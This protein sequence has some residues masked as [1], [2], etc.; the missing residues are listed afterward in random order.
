MLSELRTPTL[1][2]VCV[3]I[4]SHMLFMAG[5]LT[6]QAVPLSVAQEQVDYLSVTNVLGDPIV[7]ITS[8]WA[9]AACVAPVEMARLFF[10]LLRDS[11]NTVDG[12]NSTLEGFERADA[13]GM[14]SPL[15]QA[16][17]RGDAMYSA[18]T[19]S[20]QTANAET[21]EA[22][23][24]SQA[25][26][27]S[28]FGALRGSVAA[29]FAERLVLAVGGKEAAD[30]EGD[31]DERRAP[32]EADDALH[33]EPPRGEFPARGG[34]DEYGFEPPPQWALRGRESEVDWVNPHENGVELALH[35]ERR[36]DSS[37]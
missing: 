9:V 23:V 19:S 16:L 3:I 32:T 12:V 8:L 22:Y 2:N 29:N 10:D 7:W 28:V 13:A 25:R 17:M 37:L 34:G 31:T 21:L 35:R 4:G 26:R 6:I 15:D 24:E 30:A 18:D 14:L 5:T 36:T 1:I 33:F 11:A 20:G 27:S